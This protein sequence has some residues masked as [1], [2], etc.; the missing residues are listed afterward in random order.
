[1]LSPTPRR[2]VITL[3]YDPLLSVIASVGAVASALLLRVHLFCDGGQSMNRL[4]RRPMV[5]AGSLALGA[6]IAVATTV[7]ASAGPT[8]NYA[9]GSLASPGTPSGFQAEAL[10]TETVVANNVNING[11]LSTGT[12]TDTAGPNSAYAKV[13]YPSAATS[14]TTSG[15]T[16]TLSLSASQVAS[17]CSDGDN[18]AKRTVNIVKGVLTEYAADAT[19]GVPES[20]QLFNLPQLPAPGQA[21]SFGGATVTLNEQNGLA[22]TTFAIHVATPTQKLFLAVVRCGGVS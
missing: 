17:Y 16:Y 2:R 1:M 8:T 18:P 6:G 14:W 7:P 22:G 15:T 11:L 3:G 12:T 19:T 20:Y 13:T 4:L 9:F 5:L 21:Y 10:P